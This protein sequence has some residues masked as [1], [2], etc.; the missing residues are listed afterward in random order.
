[1]RSISLMNSNNS[2]ESLSS[3]N[4]G[5]L[6]RSCPAEGVIDACIGSAEANEQHLRAYRERNSEHS[7]KVARVVDQS[8]ALGVQSGPLAGI[9]SSFK[10]LYGV[11]GYETFAGTPQSLPS[12]WRKP[13][14][15]VRALLQAG[16]VPTGKSHTVEFAF[17]GLG[18]NPHH[19]TPRN[20]WDAEQHRVPGGSSA[21]AGVSLCEGSAHLAFG[22][23]TAGSVRIPAAMTGNVGLKVTHGRWPLDGIVPLSPSF[24]TPGLLARTVSDA[25][26][27]FEGVEGALGFGSEVVARVPTAEISGLRFGV[28]SR[29]FWDELSPGIGEAVDKSLSNIERKGGILRE[30]EPTG[31]DEAYSLFRHG[32]LAAP[33]LLRFLR[34]E[35]PE[36]IN[37]LDPNVKGRVD[38]AMEISAHEYLTRQNR[39]RALRQ[40]GREWFANV[41]V[42][43]TPAVAVSPPTTQDVSVTPGYA[44]ANILA[45]R[46]T[47]VA[48]LL[49]LCAVTLPVGRDHSG[50]PASLQLMAPP[51]EERLLLRCAHACERVFGTGR[52]LLGRPPGVSE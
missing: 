4:A 45:L 5:V 8:V 24:D 44:A 7:R 40:I 12:K 41:D 35:L 16:I 18:T 46:N 33:E 25:L 9:P 22:T 49:G 11:P 26:Y 47:C 52:E 30:I 6:D 23:D 17:G 1:M 48:N 50:M 38:A 34:D 27:A 36:C 42:V 39:F 31:C 2:F 28:P 19:G 32:G 14:T 21:G 20:P 51:R 43:A 13:G 29:F 15:L 10:D 37:T 3:I